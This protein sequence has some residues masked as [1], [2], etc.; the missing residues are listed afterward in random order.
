MVKIREMDIADY[1]DVIKLWGQTEGMS[2]RDADSKERI[3]N[4]L[5][6]NPNLSFVAVS[7]NEIVGAVLVGT[8]GRRGYLQHLAVSSN[9]RGKNLGRELVS[10]AISALA[11]V[12]VPKTHLFVYNENVNAQ[13]FYEKLGWFPRDEVRMYSYNSSSNNNV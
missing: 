5:I 2:L 3:N 6:R 7:A 1:D 11:N 4:Y 8:D 13:Q 12:G 9:F 10:Q